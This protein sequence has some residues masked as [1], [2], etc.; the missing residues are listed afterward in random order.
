MGRMKFIDALLRAKNWQNT[1]NRCATCKP[2]LSRCLLIESMQVGDTL[3]P[4]E[5]NVKA[6]V[7]ASAFFLLNILTR[8]AHLDPQ[9]A[10][11]CRGHFS[12]CI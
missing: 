4:R 10:T 3:V 5:L 7:K 8:I 11:F 1:V 9:T 12:N 6:E 2:A